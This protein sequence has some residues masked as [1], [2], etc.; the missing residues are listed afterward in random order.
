M[1]YI[2]TIYLRLPVS[3]SL[4]LC[5]ICA[6]WSWHEFD[7]IYES[8]WPT[9]AYCRNIYMSLLSSYP[10]PHNSFTTKLKTYLHKLNFCYFILSEKRENFGFRERN[11]YILTNYTRL[12]YDQPWKWLSL[13]YLF[14]IPGGFK[15]IWC[16]KVN[17]L[18]SQKKEEG[19]LIN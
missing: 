13:G 3:V 19:D 17:R 8:P 11:V 16:D 6:K 1:N 9:L 4:D 2:Y 10:L 15:E 5:L 14:I 18:A 7:T 12:F